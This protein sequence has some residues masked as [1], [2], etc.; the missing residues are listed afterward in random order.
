MMYVTYL[1][2]LL[3]ISTCLNLFCTHL[4][5]TYD[6]DGDDSIPA[7]A[8]YRTPSSMRSYY[9]AHDVRI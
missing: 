7:T 3:R 9:G 6:Y 2:L 8:I 1:Y 5:D 4:R